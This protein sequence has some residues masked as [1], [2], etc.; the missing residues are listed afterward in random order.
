MVVLGI[1]LRGFDWQADGDACADAAFSCPCDDFAVMGFDETSAD[2]QAQT[3][4]AGGTGGEAVLEP[5][6]HVKDAFAFVFGDAGAAV[7]NSDFQA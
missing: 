2:G 6:E 3:C 5:I 1:A 7:G 4:A